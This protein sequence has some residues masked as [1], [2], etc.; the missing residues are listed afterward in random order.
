M[1]DWPRVT[2]V[3][4]AV[5]LAA[6]FAMVPAATLEQARVRGDA[7]H[8][9]GEA[10]AYGYFDEAEV[11][12]PARP[13]VAALRRFLAESRFEPIAAEVTVAHPTWEYIGHPDLIGW[14]NGHRT[15]VDLKTGASDGADVQVAAYV[16]G[17]NAQHPE[18]PIAAAAILHLR[19]D[20][21]YRFDEVELPHATPIWY[22]ALTVYRAQRRAA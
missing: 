21:T 4:Q 15:L 20:G 13:Y 7:V 16:E 17:W 10:L 22:A 18:A 8:A 14:L 12:E 11:P 5:G 6:D 2:R 1:T 3:I 19:D 9:A